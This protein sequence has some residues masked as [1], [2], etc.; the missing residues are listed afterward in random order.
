LLIQDQRP[1]PVRL[2]ST[3]HHRPYQPDQRH[4]DDARTNSQKEQSNFS[5]HVPP[6]G[7]NSLRSHSTLS[8]VLVDALGGEGWWLNG[9][10]S[11]TPPMNRPLTPL[12]F[13]MSYT[14]MLRVA[15]TSQFRRGRLQDLVA[16]LSRSKSSARHCIDTRRRL[17][18]LSYRPL[19]GCDGP[20]PQVYSLPPTLANAAIAAS[21]VSAYPHAALARR[22]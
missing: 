12:A 9:R 14:D 20:P 3:W 15:F 21:R 13:G 11:G 16:L 18:M 6:V 7:M 17:G 19:L 1:R 22:T 5:F 2:S 10:V 4:Q 8:Q